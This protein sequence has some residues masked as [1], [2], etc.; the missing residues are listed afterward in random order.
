MKTT[1]ISAS[2]LALLLLALL[3]AHDAL[4]R[5]TS[6]T[7]AA[8]APPEVVAAVE[9]TEAGAWRVG[10]W[11]S[12]DVRFES[13][14]QRDVAIVIHE[15]R[16]DGFRLGSNASN[17]FFGL[18][19]NGNMTL[20]HN[21]EI[22]GETWP[23][24]QFPLSDGM[25]WD[26]T[27][28][29]YEA[30]TTARAAIVH[31]PGL[32]DHPGFQFEAASYGQTFARYTYSPLVGWI[33][34]IEIIEP[35]TRVTLLSATLT[36]FGPAFGQSYYVEETVARVLLRYPE[37]MPGDRHVEVPDGYDALRV[38]LVSDADAGA[39]TATLR[40]GRGRTIASATSVGG[41]A[42]LDRAEVESGAAT[43]TLRQVGAI[44][45]RVTLEVTGVREVGADATGPTGAPDQSTRPVLPQTGQVTS[46]G[47]PVA[48]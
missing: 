8:E 10:N 33:T 13:G 41:A 29:G 45:G 39:V 12:F 1:R 4:P 21:P 25:S 42:T 19:F 6:T 16:A 22:A 5:L 46:T 38:T 20:D 47:W 23:M 14:A 9:N 37:T 26:Y 24:L 36:A 11:W 48:V 27:M 34:S 30:T 2:F 18:P 15:A 31:A 43:W 32:G 40:D 3:V 28:L 44:D 35:S 7:L 17:G